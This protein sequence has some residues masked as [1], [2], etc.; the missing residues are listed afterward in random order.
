VNLEAASIFRGGP[1]IRALT[2]TKP[3]LT[4]VDGTYSVQDLLDEASKPKPAEKPKKEEAPLRFS[5]NNIRVE[6]GSVDFDD[7]PE[8][9]IHT[10]RDLKIG[11]PF[12]SKIPSKVEI[13][14]SPSS[15]PE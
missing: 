3:S 7:R 14:P 5:V 4:L 15:R 12:L 6:G 9:T 13:T 11:I 8:K 10:V 2:V 1:V